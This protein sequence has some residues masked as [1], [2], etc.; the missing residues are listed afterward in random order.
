MKTSSNLNILCY[1]RFLDKVPGGIQTHTLHLMKSLEENVHFVHAVTSR[2][3]AGSVLRATSK[4][5]VVRTPSWN[6]DGSLAISP[7]LVA[8]TRRLQKKRNFDLVHLHFPDPMAHLAS[9]ALPRPIPRV[10]TWHADITRQ[11]MLLCFYRPWLK[12][13]IKSAA[14]I[15]VPT[16]AHITSSQF[17]ASEKDDFKIKVI[18]FGFDLGSFSSEHAEAENIKAKYPGHRVFAL[19]R[20]VSYKGFDVLIHAMQELPA[21]VQLL[22]G[23]EGPLTP[24]LRRLVAEMGLQDR[25]RFLGFVSDEALPAFYQACDVFCLPSVTTAEAFGIVQVEAMAAGK[26]VV[27]SRLN[28]G[29]D[30]VNQH[31]VTGLTVPPGDSSALAKSLNKLL[32]DRELREKY[33]QQAKA[34]ALGE[35]S[36]T[37][38]RDKTLSLYREVLEAK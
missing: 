11:K 14:A 36:L 1:G 18:P 12:A 23:G 13:A 20:H 26:P 37:A 9:L 21:G 32:T 10:I 31:E 3:S 38:M 16:P 24:D 15:I 8:Q 19:G 5:P 34:R 29:V 35:F 25:V 4:V 6:V 17:L 7:G 22:L 28:N 2:D 33:G 27:S 30:F